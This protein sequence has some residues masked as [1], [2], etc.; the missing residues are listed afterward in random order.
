MSGWWDRAQIAQGGRAPTDSLAWEESKG[1]FQVSGF[2]HEWACGSLEIFV[3]MQIL[4]QQVWVG[5]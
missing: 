2:E 5:A 3:K 1:T 4:T